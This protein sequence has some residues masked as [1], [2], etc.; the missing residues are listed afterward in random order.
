MA[1][2][3]YWGHW[4]SADSYGHHDR[5]SSGPFRPQTGIRAVYFISD[6]V[7]LHPYV[8]LA[9][10]DEQAEQGEAARVASVRVSADQTMPVNPA[11]SRCAWA[12][13]D[14]LLREYHDTEWGVPEH[15]SRALWELL[16]LEGFQAGLAWITVLRKRDAFRKAFKGFD[17]AKVARFREA[18]IERLLQDPGIIRSRAKIEATI[19]AARIYLEM[20]KSG[21]DFATFIWGIVDPRNVDVADQ[22]SAGLETGATP[23]QTPLSV[24][25]SKHLKQRG[26]KFVGPVIV[27][28]FMQASGMVNDHS[29]TC[30]RR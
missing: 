12:E 10:L 22:T 2:V 5:N 20:Q 3:R 16:M 11:K 18:D 8:S 15:D 1:L 9:L 13:S 21:E 25:M 19:N 28:A 4:N 7:C 30:F 26:F 24:E 17:P 23:T 14:P 27:Y 29:P 6:P